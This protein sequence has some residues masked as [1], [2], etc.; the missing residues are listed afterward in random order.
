[1]AEHWKKNSE[2]LLVEAAITDVWD[3]EDIR[4]IYKMFKKALQAAS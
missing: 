2:M 1:M 4:A 3:A